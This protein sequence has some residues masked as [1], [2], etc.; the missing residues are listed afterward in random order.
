M[1]RSASSLRSIVEHLGNVS[2]I[3]SNSSYLSKV[4][5]DNTG[6]EYDLPRLLFV[7]FDR[8]LLLDFWQ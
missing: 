1:H 8:T 6:V 2:G 4:C 5:G 7:L 3:V